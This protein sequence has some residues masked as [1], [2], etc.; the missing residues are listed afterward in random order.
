M[1]E[2]HS[3]EVQDAGA[4]AQRLLDAVDRRELTAPKRLVRLLEA[5]VQV[6]SG[7]SES[8]DDAEASAGPD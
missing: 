3:R 1:A 5:M 4:L 2:N 7:S 6:G 8:T